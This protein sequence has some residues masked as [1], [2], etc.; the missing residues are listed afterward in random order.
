MFHPDK[1]NSNWLHSD[2]WQLFTLLYSSTGGFL[3]WGSPIVSPIPRPSPS[4]LSALGFYSY[5]IAA[6]V[7]RNWFIVNNNINKSISLEQSEMSLSHVFDI[8]I[9]I[10]QYM[11]HIDFGINGWKVKVIV[12]Y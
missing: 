3:G 2:A 9:G 1:S 5:P 7:F 11:T 10:G 4:V 12:I 8:F 6:S